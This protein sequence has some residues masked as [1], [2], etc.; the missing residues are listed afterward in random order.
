MELMLE[1]IY[2][3]DIMERIYESMNWMQLPQYRVHKRLVSILEG[4]C[5]TNWQT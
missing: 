2:I 5:S 3:Y 4:M 1:N